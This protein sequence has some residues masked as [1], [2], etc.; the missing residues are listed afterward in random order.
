VD[1]HRDT[2]HAAVIDRVGRRLADAEFAA[3][4]AGYRQLPRWL[5]QHGVVGL[6]GVEGTG[7]YGAGL[8]RYLRGHG[9]VVVEVDRADRN[10][11]RTHGT[12][13]P[14]DAYAA[15]TAALNGAASG[16]PKTGDGRVEAHSRTARRSSGPGESSHAG[17]EP[18]QRPDRRCSGRSPRDPAR[19]AH[20]GLD[21]HLRPSTP[22]RG[23]SIGD[24]CDQ[25]PPSLRCVTSLAATSS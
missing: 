11:R 1:T 10:G 24:L 16:T 17:D 21:R 2:H 23:R 19:A 6:V 12:S 18:A 15:A 22:A 4:P 20:R 5:N 3:S 9:I 25:R 7:A 14:I 13:D 8:A